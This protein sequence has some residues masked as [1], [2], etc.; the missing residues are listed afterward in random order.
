MVDCKTCKAAYR[1]AGKESIPCDECPVL[2]DV[3]NKFKNDELVI[4]E[5]NQNTGGP[6]GWIC[7]VCGKGN[8]PFSSTCNCV[9]GEF[10]APVVTCASIEGGKLKDNG[11][12]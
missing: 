12:Y 1:I 7:P 5:E 6:V 10:I 3:I 2:L 4:K 9:M 11:E 8:S